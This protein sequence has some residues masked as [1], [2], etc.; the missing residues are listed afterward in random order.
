M[1][2]VISLIYMKNRRGSRAESWGTPEFTGNELQILPPT[3]TTWLLS[4]TYASLQV[5]KA[6]FKPNAN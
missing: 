4:V 2:V 3:S 5:I 1:V 6:E